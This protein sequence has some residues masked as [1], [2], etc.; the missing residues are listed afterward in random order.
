MPVLVFAVSVAFWPGLLSAA[1]APRWCLLAVSLPLVAWL[2]P[3]NLDPRILGLALVGLAYAGLS[4]LWAPD[5]LTGADNLFHLLILAG[6]FLAGAALTD[7]APV[8][9]ALAAGLCVSAGI[10]VFQI[11]GH[12]PVE[13][14]ASPAGLF[15]N[16]DILGETIAPVLVWLVCTKRFAFAVPLALALAL[17]QS[18]V[19]MIAVLVAL[20][21]AYPRRTWPLAVA[22]LM[23]A[24]LAYAFSWAPFGAGKIESIGLRLGVWNDAISGLSWLGKGIGSFTAIYPRW[25]YAHSDVLQLAFETGAIGVATGG[26]LCVFLWCRSQGAERT[27]LVALAIEAALSFPLHAPVTAFVA[28]LL[29]GHLCRARPRLCRVGYVCG[30]QLVAAA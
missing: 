9:L 12:S 1:T 26:V 14:A 4:L 29:A 11:A 24:N 10:A 6:A 23:Y 3:R 18:R 7:V 13:Q 8:M 28:S 5:R 16:R 19:G 20:F 22:A 27:L 30:G 21:L 2:D 25:D 15:Y 17:S